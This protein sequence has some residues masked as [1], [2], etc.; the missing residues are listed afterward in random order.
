MSNT[1]AIHAADA[2]QQLHDIHLPASSGW[3]PP[4]PGWWLLAAVGMLALA[5]AARWWRGWQR[6]NRR[7]RAAQ[8]ELAAL[9]A[10]SQDDSAWFSQLNALLKR[11]ARDCY[12]QRPVAALTGDEWAAFL[13]NSGDK[14]VKPELINTMVNACWQPRNRC[15]IEQAL[16][17]AERWLLRHKQQLR[18][19]KE[20]LRGAP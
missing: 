4:A 20:S 3:W 5:L 17:F 18:S 8:Q 13:H 11:V 6:R 9:R 14:D 15:D 7:W 12:P 1:T 10:Q 19:C 16:S 2:L